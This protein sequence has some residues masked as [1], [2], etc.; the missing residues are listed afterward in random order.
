M[1]DRLKI[2]ISSTM[3]DLQPERN[4]VEK[5]IQKL[6]FEVI[7]AETYG[8]TSHTSRETVRTMVRACDI[9]LGIFGACYGWMPPGESISVTEIEFREARDLGKHMLIYVKDARQREPRQQEFLKRVEDFDKGLFRRPYFKGSRQL[10][11][12]VGKDIANLVSGLTLRPKP[13]PSWIDILHWITALALVLVLIVVYIVG[14]GIEKRNECLHRVF[15]GA[16]PGLEIVPYAAN[17]EARGRAICDKML[18]GRSTYL[19]VELQAYQ[20]S[21]GS[22]SGVILILRGFDVRNFATLSFWVKGEHG[23]ERFGLKMKN[24]M[25]QETLVQVADYLSGSGVDTR[26]KQVFTPVSDFLGVHYLPLDS[27]T[28]FSAGDVAGVKPQKFYITEIRLY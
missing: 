11:E 28:I 19:Q 14:Q 20:S 12:W 26:W 2:F 24:S 1:A 18:D 17:G 22:N 16:P 5:A 27:I 4:A 3:K 7:R 6:G 25:G 15:H 8:S 10:T 23:G 21:A 13:P 9:Y